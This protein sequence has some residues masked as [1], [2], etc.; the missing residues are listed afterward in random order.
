MTPSC[1]T[2][3]TRPRTRLSPQERRQ[4]ILA[5]ARRCCVRNGAFDLSLADVAQEAGI[6]RNLVYHYFKNHESL[7]EA[8]L[9]AEGEILAAR[10]AEIKPLTG[11][12]PRE[13][14]RRL[15]CAFLDFTAE[16][17][18]GFSLLHNAPDIKPLLRERFNASASLFSGRILDLLKL[19]D[20]PASHAAGEAA[21][22][23]LLRFAYIERNALAHKRDAAAD[24]CLA[25]I[26]AAANG[27][28]KFEEV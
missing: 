28:K 10:A 13:T 2:S 21:T 9:V 7:L 24:L 15:I 22:G 4:A 25:V 3:S 12:A 11:E 26:E 1:E 17:A 14:L 27:V 5:A 20:T 18:D 19:P 23:F 16:R 6:S 8:L